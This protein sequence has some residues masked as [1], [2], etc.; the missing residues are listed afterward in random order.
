MPKLQ[1]PNG[2]ILKYKSVPLFLGCKQIDKEIAARNLRDL[3]NFLSS[4]G[5][6]FIL[7]YGTLLGAVREHDFISH[8]E[9]IDLMVDEK[10][11]EKFFNLLPELRK[12]G[13]EVCRYDRRSLLSIIKDGEY[14]DFYFF[15]PWRKGLYNSGGAVV[16]EEFV[17]ETA[18][19]E[20]KGEKYLAPKDY[21][22]YLLSIYGP[23]W[24]TPIKFN[25]YNQPKYKIALFKLKE[26]MKDALPD[27]IYFHFANKKVAEQ[28]ERICN[29]LKKNLGME[30]PEE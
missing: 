10:Y 12:I 28:Q 18:P 9:D 20:F 3:K 14:I 22:K 2:T 27:M 24:R 16:L 6:E 8:D 25:N 19:F 4:H 29:R 13:F 23:N 5:V 7:A 30:I 1:L 11:R 21:E 15:K 17:K 26:H